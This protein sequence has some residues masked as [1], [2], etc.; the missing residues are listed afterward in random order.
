MGEEG[1]EETQEGVMSDEPKEKPDVPAEKG[2]S[3]ALARHGNNSG[4]LARSIAGESIP[5]ECL[6]HC[7]SCGESKT[8]K[9]D[10]DEISALGNDIRSYAGPCWSC[11]MMTLVPRDH[12]IGDVTSI[13]DR[14][15]E[16]FK[17]RVDTALDEV[18]K[19]VGKVIGGAFAGAAQSKGEHD[20]LPDAKDIDVN[21]LKPRVPE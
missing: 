1:S 18:E 11:Q 7:M 13:A 10:E 12:L 9:F 5:D 2:A 15:D 21:D 6:F 17:K 16:Q 3:V 8:L 14:A 19:R 20:D 4:K